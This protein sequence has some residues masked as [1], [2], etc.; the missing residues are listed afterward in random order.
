[1]SPA[2]R[3]LRRIQLEVCVPV[4]RPF[5]ALRFD[6]GVVGELGGVIAPPYD[7]VGDDLRRELLASSSH[8]VV[9]LDF[10]VEEFGDP[11]PDD[12][13]RRAARLLSDWRGQG[14]LRQ[15]PRPSI[16]VYEQQFAR[17]GRTEPETRRG[18]FARVGLQPFG[19]EIRPHE[20][21]MPGPREDRYRLLRATNV[22][23]SPIVAMYRDPRHRVAPLLEAITARPAAVDV[24]DFAGD[25]HR[26]WVLTAG[27]DGSAETLAEI[28]GRV[29]LTIADGHHR[30]ET[31]LRFQSERRVGA[32][33]TEDAEHGYD[34]VLMLLL[35]P[36]AG[37]LLVLPTHRVVRGLGSDGLAMLRTVLSSYFRMSRRMP[38]DELLRSLGP[39]GD[40]PP[41][42][43]GRMGLW[44][45]DGGWILQAKGK[46]LETILGPG[47]KAVRRLD[48]SMLGAVLDAGAGLDAAAIAAGERLIY[49]HDAAEAI[50][51]VDAGT[52]GAD[53]AFL[54]DPT[55]AA[56]ILAVAAEGDVM[57][58]KSTYIYPKAI[59]GLVINPLES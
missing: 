38:A 20:R 42:S 30:Y 39:D 29:P 59:T 11:D 58:Q 2:L 50:A 45:R 35:E 37:P 7:V 48:V 25:R 55:P 13:Y 34:F 46:A 3:P 1:M 31:A 33:A 6:P 43:G 53:A 4:V 16:Y 9:R 54:L 32:P 22:N 15:D 19:Q 57:P 44:T 47:G 21:T 36:E 40:E 27:T 18:F 26:L 10:P 52:E 41:R 28:A 12:R 51:L 14:A 49:T 17:L 24:R 5:R 56:E 23:T 8:N